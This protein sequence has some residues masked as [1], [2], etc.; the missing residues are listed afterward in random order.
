MLVL[1][2]ATLLVIFG[3]LF[4][5]FFY[6]N[7]C[8]QHINIVLI[9]SFQIGCLFYYFS[10]QITLGRTSSTSL[11]NSG[12]NGNKTRMPIFIISSQHSTKSNGFCR[13]FFI[14]SISQTKASGLTMPHPF[15]RLCVLANCYIE[16]I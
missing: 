13:T 1:Y 12:E 2:L 11:N 4:E 3:R 8:H 16:H 15:L 5:I 7:T 9:L 10:C 14:Y 6:T